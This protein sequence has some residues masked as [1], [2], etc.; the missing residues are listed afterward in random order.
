MTLDREP[1]HMRTGCTTMSC[2]GG[3]ARDIKF[4]FIFYEVIVARTESHIKE[5]FI[6]TQERMFCEAQTM[7]PDKLMIHLDMRQTEIG[8]HQHW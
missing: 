2:R 1:V 6:F 8:R 4:K 3:K 7:P 5:K